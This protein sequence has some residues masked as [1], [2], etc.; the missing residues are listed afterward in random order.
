MSRK[1]FCAITLACSLAIP[2][3]TVYGKKSKTTAPVPPAILQM[4]ADQKVLHAL[5]RLSYGP[6]PGDVEAV[7]KFG[8]DKWIELQLHPESIPENPKLL[9]K[10]QP[11]DSLVMPS[12]M[13]VENY[14]PPQLIKAM[15]DGRAPFPDD[16]LTRIMIR[17]QVERYK[18]QE[19]SK[20]DKSPK[21]Q[22]AAK[23]IADYTQQPDLDAVIHSLTPEQQNVI[24][25]GTMLEKVATLEALPVATQ[26][27]ILD[28]WKPQQRQGLFPLASPALRRRIS[29]MNGPQQIVYSDLTDAKLLRA[30]YSSK[31]LEEV[32]TDFWFNHFNV[33]FDKGAD[34]YLVT[35]FERDAIRP[36]VLGKF[37]DLLLAT[38]E[39]SAML[40]Y[41]D[42]WESVGA[43]SEQMQ[44]FR[45]KGIKRGLNENYGRELMELHTLGVDGGYTQKDVTEVSRCFTGW[46][47]HN[48][49]RGGQFEFQP[50][51]HDNGEKIVLGVK[52][53]AGGGMEDGLKVLDML[54]KS[55]ATAHFISKQLAIRFVSDNP[56]PALIDSMAKTFLSTDGDLREVMRAMLTS[57]E[58]WTPAEFPRQGQN[59][60]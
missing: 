30:V 37:H 45:G 38:A 42:N 60:A 52:I 43:N 32:L 58:F 2:A 28:A 48:P 53:P 12:D 27:D 9:A 15:V 24:K 18:I 44:N 1:A 54:S 51:L 17:R 10:L 55:P 5:N 19:D 7:T 57:P 26:V 16:P 21:A 35:S 11:L 14:P 47:I 40:F 6:R 3:L 49:Q 56:P 20:T 31:Q 25:N 8:L 50:R 46:S 59:T 13:L 29:M 36:N 34:R 41:L 4:T 39:S 23:R 22:A 33:Y